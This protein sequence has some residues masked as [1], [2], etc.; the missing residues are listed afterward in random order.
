M[1]HHQ[2]HHRALSRA[3]APARRAVLV[4]TAAGGARGKK[5]GGRSDADVPSPPPPSAPSAPTLSDFGLGA[6]SL[7]LP[8]PR[9]RREQQQQQQQQPRPPLFAAYDDENDEDDVAAVE[10]IDPTSDAWGSGSDTEDDDGDGGSR[11][12]DEA[13]F[14]AALARARQGMLIV[15]PTASPGGNRKQR[16]LAL[17]AAAASASLS[18]SSGDDEDD[19]DAATTAT[20]TATTQPPP[21]PLGPD[22]LPRERVFLV[23]VSVRS[24][25]YARR[26]RER[27][28]EQRRQEQRTGRRPA[29]ALAPP[30]GPGEEDEEDPEEEEE[31][32]ATADDGDSRRRR[33]RKK[34]SNN[35]KNSS[36]STYGV[37][38][39]LDEL[40]RLADT[41]GLFVVGRTSQQLASPNAATYVG[42][43]KV[44]EIVAA[45]RRLQADTVIFDDE[46]SPAQL[47]NL[48]RAL[49]APPPPPPGPSASAGRRARAAMAGAC[50][51]D[52]EGL[53]GSAGEGGDWWR[54]PTASLDGD[55]DDADGYDGDAREEEQEQEPAP[56]PP[57][58][59]QRPVAVADRTALILDIFSQR[60]RTKEGKLQV[61]LAQVEYQLPRVTRMWTHLDRVGGG[62]QVKGAGEKQLEIDRRL[63]RDR[64]ALLRREL[65]GVRAHRAAHR[66][67]RTETPVPVVALVGYTNAGKSSLLNA[68]V[69]RC[70]HFSSSASAVD[71][72]FS[73]S[74]SSAAA[75]APLANSN[76]NPSTTTTLAD[77]S[78]ADG[79]VP[80]KGAV[81]AEDRLFATL[82]PTTRRVRLKPAGTEVLVTDTVGFIQKLPTSLVAAF[83][84]TLEEIAAASV[85]VHVVDAS[86]EVAGAQ[87]EA[88]S[89]VLEEVLGGREALSRMPQV[90]AWNKS[91]AAVGGAEALRRAAR[92]VSA[93][94][95]VAS[96][97]GRR[98]RGG[99]GG[100]GSGAATSSASPRVVVVSAATGDGL[101]ELL[102]ALRAQ[103]DDGW[104]DFDAVLPADEA[105]PLISA[106]HRG[107]R[108]EE[109]DWSAEGGVRVRGKAPQALAGKVLRMEER[110]RARMGLPPRAGLLGEE[111]DEGFFEDDEEDE[112][113]AA[114]LEAAGAAAASATP[115]P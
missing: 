84:A 101:D 72:A 7:P 12:S 115:W 73:F 53:E 66:A 28:E 48:E 4:V 11:Q 112:D 57:P 103:L 33:H 76:N 105:G 29:F 75:S 6:E 44:A 82:D 96:R 61:A 87:A 99:G 81:L 79:A 27:R 89:A 24:E 88:V 71:G 111:E 38:A 63:L 110:A 36:V 46:L 34:S 10:L 35:S 22:G 100:N 97:G 74:P 23:G 25:E 65:D 41:A 64:A 69:A 56:P 78:L 9:N 20:A 83:R 104:V 3:A 98:R 16:R 51:E 17:Q 50:D 113:V 39:S 68:L 21:S 15:P 92:E 80:F 91:D 18:S 5:R 62:G 47:R 32:N 102:A 93:S 67:R 55:A 106:L 40:A 2:H 95:V 8:P 43:G 54:S 70:G 85:L 114:A 13:A 31:E 49:N 52:E 14:A 45:A 30:P 59:P 19:A 42:G 107:G 58:P 60:A 77:A 109:E 108:L 94:A 26:A 86:S 90:T 37:D 1:R